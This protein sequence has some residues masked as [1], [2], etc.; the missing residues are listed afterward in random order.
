MPLS[1]EMMVWR[2][3]DIHLARLQHKYIWSSNQ[4]SEETRR[5][6]ILAGRRRSEN[7]P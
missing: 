4:E 2:S 1:A 5:A 3:P 6:Q 7:F